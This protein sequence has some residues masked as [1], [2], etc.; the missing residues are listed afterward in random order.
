M[1]NYE[2]TLVLADDPELT[3]EMVDRLFEAGCDDST[4]SICNGIQEVAFSRESDSL[5][6]AIQSAI[7]D[8]QSTGL[9]VTRIESD[10]SNI[11]HKFNSALPVA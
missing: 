9:I 7:N 8:V 2:F 10:E 1:K 3:E 5:E 6:S 11:I 4:P